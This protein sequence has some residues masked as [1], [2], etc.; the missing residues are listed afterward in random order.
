MPPTLQR[1]FRTIIFDWDGTAVVDR[2]EDATPLARLIEDLTEAGV[3][4]VVVTGT[5]FH[6]IDLQLCRHLRPSRRR[7]LFVCANRGSEVYG[8]EAR[9]RSVV[10]WQRQATPEED[11]ALTAAAE[12]VRDYARQHSDLEVRVIYDR[13]NRRKI[14]L[15]PV[16]EWA[17]PPKSRI[18]DLLVAVEGRLRG[19]GIEGGLREMFDVTRR[20][21]TEVGLLDAR[22][23]SDVKHIEVG[24]TDKGDSIDWINRNLLAAEG[25]GLSDVLVGGDEFG[26]I[27]GFPGSDDLLRERSPGA[28]HIS[29]GAEP[30]GV[31]E[32]VIHLGGGPRRFRDVLREQVRLHS[33]GGSA[34]EGDG[35]H[36]EA[37]SQ[38]DMGQLLSPTSDPLWRFDEHGYEPTIEHEAESRFALS[39]GFLGVRASLDVPT[40]ASMPRTYLAGLFEQG[41]GEY[42]VPALVPAPDWSGLDLTVDGQALSPDRG[43]IVVHS[44]TLDLRRGVLLS[45]WRHRVPGHTVAVE[46]LRFAS[47]ARRTLAGE[48]VRLSVDAP[49]TVQIETAIEAHEG[50]RPHSVGPD[51]GV[52]TTAS[53]RAIAVASA[54]TL[55]ADGMRPRPERADGPRRLWRWE[56]R[57]EVPGVLQRLVSFAWGDAQV[58]EDTARRALSDASTMGALREHLR[59]WDERWALSDVG[60]EGDEEAQRALRFAVYHLSSAADPHSEVTSIGARALT[61][62]GYLGHVFWDLEIFTLP[63]FTFTWP[64]AARALLMYRYHT[65]DGARAKAAALGYRG[66]LYAWESTDTGAETTPKTVVGLD[67]ELVQI[68]SGELEHHVSADIAYA[69]WQYWQ[70]TGD[71]DFLVSAGVEIVLETA[72]FWASRAK[73]EGDGRYH[74]RR[75]IGPDEYHEGVD[76]N[77]YT[78]AMARWNLRRGLEVADLISRRW[79]DR[80]RPLVERLGFSV[81]ELSRWR[82]VADRMLIPFD[83][84]SK[85]YEQFAGY[86]GL[87]EVDLSQYQDRVVPMDVVLGPENT[88][89][90]Q[91]LKQADVVMLL[92]L[93]DHEVPRDVQRANFDYYEPRCGQGSSLS[94]AMHALVAARTGRLDLAERFFRETAAIDLGDSM[95]NAAAGV[96]IGALG[97]LWMSTVMGFGGMSLEADGLRFEPRLPASWLGLRFRVQWRGRQVEADLRREPASAEFRLVEGQEMVLRLGEATFSL[98]PDRPLSLRKDERDG[99]WKE[100]GR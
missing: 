4:C 77:A 44:R 47:L 61:G 38:D 92:A 29:V 39:N 45:S 30:D 6:N 64:R 1:P 71:D 97:G 86:F 42:G 80:W 87:E 7:R 43:E 70:A 96:H 53:R 31:P 75:V 17:D 13:L 99:A 40:A 23:T 19:G 20:A 26:P 25:I 56:A 22:I 16:P 50:L 100:T 27:A 48:V 54:D 83:E 95:G 73:L 60:I 18:G 8:F 94:P 9:G 51:V 62:D 79:P 36:P 5:N 49:S 32:G 85:L 55:Q 63:F 69:V 35:S 81:E 59:A 66:A 15:I 58:A 33:G 91:V 78:N 12:R 28:V 41:A 98:A 72:S 10:R 89:R 3:W 37:L 74:I 84:Q 82:D 34:A 68:L 14:D 88:R 2:S 65:L 67:G 11:A 57:P 93:L 24:L 76:D 52:W 90:T 46:S 21:A